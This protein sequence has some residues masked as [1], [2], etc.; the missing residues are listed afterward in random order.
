[1]ILESTMGMRQ[2]GHMF[3]MMYVHFLPLFFGLV[4]MFCPRSIT[5]LLTQV[6]CSHL[7]VEKTKVS[8]H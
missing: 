6:R 5:R 7:E 2:Q 1:M 3:G 4:F 8:A